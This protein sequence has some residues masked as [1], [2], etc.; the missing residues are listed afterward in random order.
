MKIFG[1]FML[2]FGFVNCIPNDILQLSQGQIQ[3]SILYSRNG[4][5]FNAFQG[6]PYAKPPISDLRFEVKHKY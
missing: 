6:I 3:G 5:E 2:L 4:R 1:I